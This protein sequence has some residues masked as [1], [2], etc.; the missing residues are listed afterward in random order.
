MIAGGGARRAR[1]PRAAAAGQSQAGPPGHRR[2]ARCCA[3]AGFLAIIAASALIQGSHA[4]YY[5]FAS[6]A[7]HQS[8]FGGLTIAV[9]W[10]FGVMAEIVLFALSPRFT[11]Q[12]SMLVVIAALS[13]VARWA[14]IAQDPPIAVLAVVQLAHGLTFGLTMV[15]TMDC[16]CATCPAM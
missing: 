13:A 11:L 3:I 2:A 9:L 6:I 5:V 8:G 16:W 4:A 7:W 14:I 15:G 12:P 1:Q 10:S